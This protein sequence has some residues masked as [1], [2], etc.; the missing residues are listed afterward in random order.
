MCTTKCNTTSVFKVCEY[1]SMQIKVINNS[2]VCHV[3]H[4]KKQKT[5][6]SWR[7]SG[8]QLGGGCD[9]KHL[10][11]FRIINIVG[12]NHVLNLKLTEPLRG[13]SVSS[14]TSRSVM[15][16]GGQASHWLKSSTSINFLFCDTL[17]ASVRCGELMSFVLLYL[18]AS[19]SV[20]N[21][22]Q[23]LHQLQQDDTVAFE[24][25]PT[26]RMKR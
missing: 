16:L 4:T 15:H 25:C 2:T 9:S 21:A 24:L 6:S 23:I 3:K 1:P 17:E 18:S 13:L 10:C 7:G 5:W 11:P 26:Q 14:C 19:C 22:Q 8:T 12:R 20:V